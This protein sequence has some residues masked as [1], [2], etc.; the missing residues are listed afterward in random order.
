MF[1]TDYI[2]IEDINVSDPL[3]LQ[4]STDKLIDELLPQFTGNTHTPAYF[5][6]LCAIYQLKENLNIKKDFNKFAREIECIW[7]IICIEN[8]DI[9]GVINKKKFNTI[10]EKSKKSGK[11]S[12]EQIRRNTSLFSRYSYGVIGHYKQPAKK[13]GLLDQEENLTELGKD[14]AKAWNERKERKRFITYIQDNYKNGYDISQFKNYSQYTLTADP[15]NRE[16]K[17]WGNYINNIQNS[18]EAQELWKKLKNFTEFQPNKEIFS[19]PYK[20]SKL[21]QI[22]TTYEWYEQTTAIIRFLFDYEYYRQHNNIKFQNLPKLVNDSIIKLTNLLSP[23][24]IGKLRDTPKILERNITRSNYKDTIR[25]IINIHLEHQKSKKR[26]AFFN[27]NHTINLYKNCDTI[28]KVLDKISKPLDLV[29]YYPINFF[30]DKVIT[31][32]NYIK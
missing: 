13:W 10:Y 8:E 16:K 20:N 6:L 12:L 11:I 9:K 4:S 29:D 18:P 27:E 21:K 2:C 7:G 1:F 25:E 22:I 5:G 17:T 15:A 24:N 30:F 26:Q 14:L 19:L 28:E 3:G 31:W 32:N 23:N